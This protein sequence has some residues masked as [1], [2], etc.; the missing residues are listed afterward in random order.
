MFENLKKAWN[1][2]KAWGAGVAAFVPALF[3]RDEYGNGRPFEESLEHASGAY[4]EAYQKSKDANEPSPMGF[5]RQVVS[6]DL[7]GLTNTLESGV[8]KAAKRVANF[9]GFSSNKTAEPSNTSQAQAAKLAKQEV[10]D[11]LK[12]AAENE[13]RHERQAKRRAERD[14]KLDPVVARQEAR[15]AAS[16]QVQSEKAPVKEKPKS[17]VQGK[18]DTHV[19]RLEQ[20]REVYAAQLHEAERRK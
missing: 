7:G 14:K 10:S 2:T 8:K 20:R 3:A 18:Q 19:A 1:V 17:V 11:K 13:K 6:G 4:K 16:S 15:K 12:E 9:F 5:A